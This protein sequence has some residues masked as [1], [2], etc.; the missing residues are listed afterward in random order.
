MLQVS[1]L[2]GLGGNMCLQL[3]VQP[4]AKVLAL[5]E[6]IAHRLHVPVLFQVLIFHTRVLGDDELLAAHHPGDGE[7]LWVNI[8]VSFHL[9]RRCLEGGS[10]SQKTEALKGL[11]QRGLV[12]DDR[13]TMAAAALEDRSKDVR[14]TAVE[15][16]GLVGGEAYG[17][18]VAAVVAR[19][20]SPYDDVRLAAVQALREVARRGDTEAVAALVPRLEDASADVREAAVAAFGEIAEQ[21]RGW[22]IA[23]VRQRLQDHS[24]DVRWKALEA[25]GELVSEKGDQGFVAEVI[26]CLEMPNIYVRRWAAEVLGR[27]TEKGDRHAIAAVA[28]HM[29]HRDDDVRMAA[30]VAL[31]KIAEKG[32]EFAVSR[33][34]ECL[35][36]SD[37]GVRLAAIQARRALLR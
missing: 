1:A 11:A 3:V 15:V 14:E 13:C 26:S 2:L 17:C 10:E 23:R 30:G 9:A 6:E 29:D 24:M 19:L 25:L 8:L 21:G 18:A 28:A 31:G 20:G 27:V 4:E 22:A 7:V 35:G 32:D 16:L 36:H 34:N 12:G 33:L 5:K 37:P